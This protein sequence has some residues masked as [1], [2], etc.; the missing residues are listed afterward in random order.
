V[1]NTKRP[2]IPA[3]DRLEGSVREAW[4]R[5]IM[6][7]FPADAANQLLEDARLVHLQPGEVFYRGAHRDSSMPLALVVGGLV[8]ILLMEPSGRQVTIRYAPPGSVVGLPWN[9]LSPSDERAGRP[10]GDTWLAFGGPARDAQAVRATTLLHLRPARFRAV[11]RQNAAACWVV[12]QHLAAQLLKAQQQLTAELFL[13]VRARVAAHLLSLAER[14]GRELVV[15]A[16][17]EA[18]AG[19]MGSVREVVSRELKRM[20]RDG[21]VQRVGGIT[22]YLRIIDAA[23]LRDISIGRDEALTDSAS[24]TEARTGSRIHVGIGE[25]AAKTIPE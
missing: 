25:T 10:A 20:E 21:L 6:A 13:P 17:H 4:K 24:P 18:I 12:S 15:R 19:A 9:L 8:R 11:M 7:G 22:G 1:T 5:S 3:L 23:T 16:R 2:V 14:D